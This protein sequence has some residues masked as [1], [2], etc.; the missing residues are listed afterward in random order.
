MDG[1]ACVLLGVD[2]VD[3]LVLPL[4][5]AD[6]QR[7]ACAQYIL[8]MCYFESMFRMFICFIINKSIRSFES[9]VYF[10]HN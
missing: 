2:P 7:H 4:G 1:S 9:R 8:I 6:K 3:S 10:D 5:P